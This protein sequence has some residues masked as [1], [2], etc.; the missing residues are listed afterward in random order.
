[1]A[2]NKH[3]FLLYTDVHYTVK[4]LTDIQAGRL[5]KHILSYVNDENPVMDDMLIDIAFEPIKQSLKRDLIKYRAIREKRSLAGKSSAN[6]RQHMS[7]HVKQDQ[8]MST[9]ST[10][11]VNDNVNVIVSDKTNNDISLYPL[12]NDIQLK[13]LLSE[14]EMLFDEKVR[15]KTKKQRED[16]AG[17]LDK[18]IR[19]DGH[20]PEEILRIIR[21]ARRDPFWS[22]NFI[23]LLKLR[24]KNKEG[25]KY[26]DVFKIKADGQNRQ[27]N[28]RTQGVTGEQLAGLISSKFATNRD[29]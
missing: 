6:K 17:V 28:Q 25:I 10:V 26:Y 12:S 7:T 22:Q 8:H 9:H 29:Q 2:E 15:P 4:K 21:W 1:M 13:G 3:S 5:F 20:S 23:S 18:L 27:G 16:W 19:I 11:L 14:V 24:L